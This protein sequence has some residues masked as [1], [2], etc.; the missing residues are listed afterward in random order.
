MD[1]PQVESSQED[2][3]ASADEAAVEPSP[4]E[5]KRYKV[6]VDAEELEIDEEE[7]LKG[8]QTSKSSSKRFQEASAL[9]KQVEKLLEDSRKDPRKM[10]EILGINP[11]EFSE[12]LLLQELEESLLSPEEK[13]RKAEREELESYRKH[14]QTQKQKEEAA[15][16]ERES[17]QVAEEIDEQIYNALKE[18]GLKPTARNIARMAEYMLAGLDQDDNKMDAKRAFSKVRS[19]T[20]QDLQ[21]LFSSTPIEDLVKFLPKEML[22]ALRQFDIKNA[23]K[24]SPHNFNKSGSKPQTD[25][26]SEKPRRRSIDELLG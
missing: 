4:V 20:N 18:S 1:E 25:E 15:R 7:L 8:Y 23:T 24:S 9:N 13:E 11:R 14:T 5:K 17:E 3:D 6:K 10:F 26:N 16:I 19:D 22:A 21:D 12:Q 2:S